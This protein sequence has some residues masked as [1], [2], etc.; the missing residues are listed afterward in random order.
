M[1]GIGER[2]TPFKVVGVKP[3]FNDHE[4]GGVSAFEEITE[5]SFGGKWKVIYYYPKD[6]TFVC[7]TEIVAFANL[8][9]AFAERNAV[10]M[11][12]STDNEFCKLAWRRAHPDLSRLNHWS[13]A[14]NLPQYPANQSAGLNDFMGYRGNLI[15]QL[16][17]RDLDAGVALR[18]TYIVDPNNVIQHVSANNLNVGRNPEE[19]LRILDALQTD[20]LCGCNREVGGCTL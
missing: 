20:Q 10:L 11:G 17:V 12:G 2:I 15:D 9:D 4:E 5:E 1:R 14:D 16:G 6:F 19:T 3:G 8:K 18:V 13:F 7:P